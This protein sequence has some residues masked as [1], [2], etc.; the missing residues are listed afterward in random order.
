M[1]S[2][3]RSLSLVQSLVQR[4]LPLAVAR[5]VT[6]SLCW[7]RACM[8]CCPSGRQE[9]HSSFQ[10]TA[11]KLTAYFQWRESTAR[12]GMADETQRVRS[13]VDTASVFRQA[14]LSNGRHSLAACQGGCSKEI[15]VREPWLLLEDTEHE[16]PSQRTKVEGG[17]TAKATAALGAL[18]YVS[19]MPR[20]TTP[21]RFNANDITHLNQPPNSLFAFWKTKCIRDSAIQL[22]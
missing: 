11:G 7:T 21:L 13:A 20:F 22:R 9:Q 5:F 19:P 3:S 12:L 15:A 10:S 16:P 6:L 14:S 8:L 2:I 17:G 18:P 1:N 4:F